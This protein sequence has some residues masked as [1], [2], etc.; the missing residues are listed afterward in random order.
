MNKVALIVLVV[1][2]L[3]GGGA[4]TLFLSQS[5]PASVTSNSPS[6]VVNNTVNTNSMPKSMAELIAEQTPQECT[7]TDERG[8]EGLVQIGDNKMHGEFTTKISA[9]QSQLSHMYV[10]NNIVYISVQGQTR[11]MKMDISKFNAPAASSRPGEVDI[12]KKIAF[13]CRPWIV[14]PEAFHLEEGVDYQDVG[15]IVV[16]SAPAVPTDLKATQCAA[17]QNLPDAAKTQCLQALA[18][19]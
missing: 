10:D 6:P 8:N 7:F 19:N 16:P 18:C 4:A 17:C 11:G 5:Q 9:N 15:A 3:L 2:L 14:D 1:L 12:N 13:D